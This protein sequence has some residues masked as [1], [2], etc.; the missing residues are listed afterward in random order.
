MQ[1]YKKIFLIILIT[2]LVT[3]ILA[4]SSVSLINDKIQNISGFELE[5]AGNGGVLKNNQLLKQNMQENAIK[6]KN[7]NIKDKKVI[8]C[9]NAIGVKLY[10]DGI[11]VVGLSEFCSDE[12]KNESPAKKSGVKKGDLIKKVNNKTVNNLED[13]IYEWENNNIVKLELSRNGKIYKFDVE[14]KKAKS[15]MKNKIGVWVRDSTAGIG[16][17]TFYDNET[18]KFAAL[19]HG[20]T[21]TDTKDIIPIKGG[22][23]L[24]ASI[25]SVKKGEK[26]KPGELEGMFLGSKGDIGKIEKN[27]SLGIYGTITNDNDIS[28]NEP[29]L[30]AT[31]DEVKEGKAYILTSI[32]AQNIE[33]YEIEIQK[34]FSHNITSTK[35]MIIKITDKKLL[36]KTGGIVQ[37][38]S[39]SPILQNGKL[40]GAVTHVF[41]N[42]PTRG[43]GI[44]IENMLAEAE[45]IK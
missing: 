34:K 27:T 45:K 24:G 10:S 18:K 1:S 11:L 4:F 44:F 35:G 3:G 38:M 15:D 37:G 17:M 7:N 43:Y 41:V 23:I 26:G 13:F 6:I 9:G 2:V 32:C 8:P 28:K 21:D 19:G 29:I 40:I 42:D 31:N 12:G 5:E 36:E 33:K 30:V 20:V 25:L 22:S 14:C 16:T 39:G